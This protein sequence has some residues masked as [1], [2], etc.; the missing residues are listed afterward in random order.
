MYW[1]TDTYNQLLPVASPRLMDFKIHYQHHKTLTKPVIS[2]KAPHFKLILIQPRIGAISVNA[3]LILYVALSK[4][5]GVDLVFSYSLTLHNI[6]K[7]IYLL[8]L[9]FNICHGN[10]PVLTCHSMSIL[11]P[12]QDY[13]ILDWIFTIASLYVSIFI[14]YAINLLFLTLKSNCSSGPN[15]PICVSYSE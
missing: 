10:W 13:T 14:V 12:V 1:I 8:S 5:H 9:A 4:N 3:N 7:I 6:N 15:P 11:L 2:T